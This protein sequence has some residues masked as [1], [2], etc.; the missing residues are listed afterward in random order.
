MSR[1]N[2]NKQ[3]KRTIG[4][5]V[6][7]NR[8]IISKKNRIWVPTRYDSFADARK[9]HKGIFLRSEHEQE[10]DGVSGL[11][12]S[13]EL[14]RHLWDSREQKN[15]K[16]GGLNEAQWKE[17]YFNKR[18]Y[19]IKELCRLTE[20]NVEQMIEDSFWS[21][22]DKI[23]GTKRTIIADSAVPNRWHIM[24]ERRRYVFNDDKSL[25]NYAIFENGKIKTQ[26]GV[27]YPEEFVK[28]LSALIDKYEAVRT[29]PHFDSNH[30]PIQE[31]I[32]DFNLRDWFLQYHRT[33]D[34]DFADF[35]LTRNPEK[36]E[37]EMP[38][39]RGKTP[40]EGIALKT[41][42]Y[43]G[44]KTDENGNIINY[45]P[46]EYP[47]GEEASFDFHYNSVFSDVMNRKRKAFFG[48]MEECKEISFIMQAMCGHDAIAPMFK[49]EVSVKGD[50]DEILE[51][52]EDHRTPYSKLACNVEGK[53]AFIN[54]HLTSD[55]TRAFVKKL[56]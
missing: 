28:G 23:K 33:R 49:P 39:V 22:W 48:A 8:D 54:L 10:Y 40:K 55:G 32:T 15:F 53:N 50:F 27:P 7:D 47:Q 1:R 5:Y 30:A 38:F 17:L 34:F 13:V 44:R 4:D 19:N 36:G 3:P 52:S 42:V 2:K 14:G 16:P 56:D 6:H 41:T 12:D 21:A 11:L 20:G 24:S 31:W 46:P 43:Y 25:I 45:F 18:G 9:S 35:E 26:Y 37:F 29:L 51:K